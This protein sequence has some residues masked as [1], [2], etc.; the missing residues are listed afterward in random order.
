MALPTPRT[1]RSNVTNPENLSQYPLLSHEVELSGTAL[2]DYV[3]YRAVDVDGDYPAGATAPAF[4]AIKWFSEDQADQKYATLTVEGTAIIEVE[5]AATITR[6]SNV[7]INASGKAVASLAGNY[8]FGTA[9]N[10]S[11]G[12]T[13][14]APHFIEVK[15]N[16]F[17]L[18]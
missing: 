9:L 11:T 7:S 6:G 18:N 2:T 4:G 8:V 1:A 17:Q 10:S 12:S 3:R 5:P 15:I 16:V 14:Q 13:V